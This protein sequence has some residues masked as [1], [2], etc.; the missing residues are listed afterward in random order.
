VCDKKQ[1]E[2]KRKELGVARMQ[3]H[4]GDACVAC[5]AGI[6]EK[7]VFIVCTVLLYHLQACHS[8]S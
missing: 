1:G 3:S 5:G 8:V 2:G 4:A 7:P 6:V